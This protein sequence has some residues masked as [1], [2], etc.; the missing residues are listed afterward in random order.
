[1][2]SIPAAAMKQIMAEVGEKF[3]SKQ[4]VEEKYVTKEEHAALQQR[5]ML[6]LKRPF[7]SLS[8]KK[9]SMNIVKLMRAESRMALRPFVVKFW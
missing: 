7:M 5:S 8:T 3:V 6:C 2:A 4:E 1:M 9:F